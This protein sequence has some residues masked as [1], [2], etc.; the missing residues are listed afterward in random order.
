MLT[1]IEQST[2]H[3][4]RTIEA[5]S[6]LSDRGQWRPKVLLVTRE[7]GSVWILPIVAHVD[8]TFASERE[9]NAYAVEMAKKW[10]DKRR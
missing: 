1:G 7:G 3:R 2:D 6:Y 5:Q 4:G 8:I 9:A 10:I